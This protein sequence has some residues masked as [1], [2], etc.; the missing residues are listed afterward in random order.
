MGEGDFNPEIVGSTPEQTSR[1]I[2][3]ELKV[4]EK[5]VRVGDL[6]KVRGSSGEIESGWIFKSFGKALAIVEKED[7]GEV[8]R[9]F[10]PLNEFRSY[11]IEQETVTEAKDIRPWIQRWRDK[12]RALQMEGKINDIKEGFLGNCNWQQV[13]YGEAHLEKGEGRYRGYLMVEPENIPLALAILSS[14]AEGR[15]LQGK[16]TE[17]KWLLKT[18]DED[19][20]DKALEGKFTPKDLGEY[21]L[22]APEDPRIVIYADTVDEVKE[23]L[24]LLAENPQWQGIEDRRRA[25]FGGNPPRRPGTNSFIDEK[26]LEWK[27]LNW[28]DQRGYS[29][30]EARDPNWRVKKT[31]T[32]TVS[33]K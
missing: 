10:I 3:S 18:E 22:L 14:R 16:T 21:Q 33:I 26:S 19:W 8:L 23:I 2:N 30:N 29:E 9:N 24:K 27:S 31:G 7:Q 11:Q 17:F 32:S 25:K 4:G 12:F 1:P 6:V 5:V 20:V 13:R 28:N 15:K